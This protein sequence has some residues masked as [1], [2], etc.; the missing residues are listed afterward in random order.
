LTENNKFY[1]PPAQ[2]VR[3][4][5]IGAGIGVVVF[6]LPFIVGFES[7]PL[8]FIC[9]F[10][11]AIAAIGLLYTG[12]TFRKVSKQLDEL[13]NGSGLLAHWTYAADE[14][15]SYIDT[16][17][18]RIK[19]DNWFLFGVIAVLVGVIAI[20]ALIF[21]HDAWL[22]ILGAA[23][24][25]LLLAAISTQ[26]AVKSTSRNLRKQPAEVYIGRS[27]A[28]L[29]HRFHYWELSKSF[30][31]AAKY[32]EGPPPVLQLEYSTPNGRG[33]NEY[34]AR[35]PIPRGREEEAR[36]V[37]LKLNAEPPPEEAEEDTEE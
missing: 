12:F 8:G 5:W 16:E 24:V 36:Q 20:L 30:L 26:L 17:Q 27:G 32:Q 33:Q 21:K 19:H 9:N 31:G 29:G 7:K 15:T 1:N 34:S 28:L 10:A 2:A 13:V 25:I 3:R 11:G 6:L 23:A 14:W 37:I 35:I 22:V 18:V 4:C